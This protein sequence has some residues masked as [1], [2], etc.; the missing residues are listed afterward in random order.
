[1]WQRETYINAVDESAEYIKEYVAMAH[2]S[3]IESL[4]AG[5][6]IICKKLGGDLNIGDNINGRL[7]LSLSLYLEKENNNWVMHF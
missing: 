2:Y 7:T 3:E 1:M 4:L 6:K 5:T